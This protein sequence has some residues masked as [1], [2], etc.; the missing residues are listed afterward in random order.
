MKNIDTEL[1]YEAIADL[2]RRAADLE[3]FSAIEVWDKEAK[4]VVR[5]I[6]SVLLHIPTTKED[7][8]L[9][10]KTAMEAYKKHS[11]L[12]RMFIQDKVSLSLQKKIADVQTLLNK[13]M[14]LKETLENLVDATPDDEDEAKIMIQE[15][16]LL[17]KEFAFEKTV[18]RGQVRDINQHARA[19]NSSISNQVLFTNAKIRRFQKMSVREQKE[20]SLKPREQQIRALDVQ[21]LD[22][23]KKIHRIERIKVLSSKIE[24]F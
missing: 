13:L 2:I 7:L 15:L 9:A 18:V 21:I 1:D 14:H 4:T 23:D 24:E 6:E 12:K 19:Q 8:E 10:R 20:N 16:K 3:T 11:F 5:S 17:K 22:I